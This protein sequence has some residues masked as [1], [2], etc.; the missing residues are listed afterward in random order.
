MGPGPTATEVAVAA[1]ESTE[2]AAVA[3]V[4]GLRCAPAAERSPQTAQ[5]GWCAAVQMSSCRLASRACVHAWRQ[6]VGHAQS[7]SAS[8]S[9]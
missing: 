3:A 2:E 1:P 7:R 5:A 9:S 6:Q 8:A 4:K